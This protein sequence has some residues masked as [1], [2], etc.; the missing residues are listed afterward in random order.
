MRESSWSSEAL[1]TRRAKQRWSALV[2]AQTSRLAKYMRPRLGR[3]NW[4]AFVKHANAL[5]ICGAASRVRWPFGRYSL[6][7]RIPCRPGECGRS[8]DAHLHLD[9]D[10]PI[11]QTCSDWCDKLPVEPQSREDSIDGRNLC[12]SLFA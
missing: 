3:R 1:V 9:H 5:T 6:P 12:H 11:H 8:K 4:N 2:S 10:R 7:T